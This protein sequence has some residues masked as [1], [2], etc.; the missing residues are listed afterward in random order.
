MYHYALTKVTK[1]PNRY[2]INNLTNSNC[3]KTKVALPLLLSIVT[4]MG[5]CTVDN[6]VEEAT[7]GVSGE[8]KI[9]FSRDASEQTLTVTTNQS[10]WLATDNAEWVTTVAE[11]N[12]L[13]IKV[14]KNEV[15]RERKAMILISAGRIQKTLTIVQAQAGLQVKCFP[16]ELITDQ[17]K[18]DFQIDV[19]ANTAGWTATCSADWV[20]VEAM[21]HARMI[22]VRVLENKEIEARDANII[23]TLNNSSQDET[24][25]PVRQSGKFSY[26]LP[27]LDFEDGSR[28]SMKRFEATRRSQMISE[29]V[30]D[31][32]GWID[33]YTQSA[34][35]PL[36]TYTIHGLNAMM[37]A[38]LDAV[39]KEYLQGKHLDIM[40]DMLKEQG[41]TEVRVPRQT[42]YNPEKRVLAEIKPDYKDNTPH[43]LFT[44]YPK[45]KGTFKTF[46]SFPYTFGMTEADASRDVTVDE[47]TEYEKSRGSVLLREQKHT[48][49]GYIRFRSYE[50]RNEGVVTRRLYFFSDVEEGVLTQSVTYYD[51]FSLAFWDYRTYPVFTEEFM[52]LTEKAG[53][54]YDRLDLIDNRRHVFLNK[55]KG[56]EL[57]IHY[58]QAYGETKKHVKVYMS[59]IGG[60]TH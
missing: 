42:I 56:L 43:I 8:E 34:L 13:I 33:F 55:D 10:R 1:Q 9:L 21:P 23:I 32:S 6:D 60:A 19:E 15:Q 52:A 41:Y 36:V 20:Q 26:I 12:N 45:Q 16:N 59:K 3:M 30:T 14:E 47:V 4:F 44:Y 35:Y 58:H 51:N 31:Y 54:K 50:T 49:S 11:G 40:L 22:K 57:R 24:S 46:E 25:I 18:K 2:L 28:Y 38:Q 27:F 7:L 17:W 29:N 39:N 53:F 48:N 37:H 5:S